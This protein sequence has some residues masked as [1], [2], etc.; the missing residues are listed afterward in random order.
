MGKRGNGEGSICRRPDGRWQGSVSLGRDDSGKLLRKYFYGKTRKEVA[1]KINEAVEKINKGSFIYNKD[2]P[3]AKIWGQIWLWEYKRNSIKPRTFDQ[4]ETLLRVHVF[5][6]IGDIKLVDLKTD[7]IQRLINE[8]FKNG[9][10]VRTIELIKV[11]LHAMLKQAKRNKLVNENICENVILPKKSKKEIRVLDIN[12]QAKLIDVLKGNYISRG[13]LLALYTGMRKGEVLALTWDDFDENAKTISVCKSLGR[14]RTYED[15]GAKT[16]LC[17]NSPKTDKSRRVIPL[18]NS[19]YEL[20][21]E[22]RKQQKK[23]MGLVGDFYN[24]NNLIFSNNTGTYID[25]G[26]FTR[27]LYK[28]CDEAGIQRINPHALRHSFATRGLEAD[29]SLKSLQE[30]LGHSSISITGDIYTHV[31]A[32]QKKKEISKLNSIF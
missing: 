16:K 12:E 2:N 3:T 28:C 11:I 27:K 15:S 8:M 31:L 6:A 30:L 22:H 1:D 5:P 9:S 20:L 32:E 23:Y 4:Y 26:N 25:P 29:M 13:L 19:A 7:H 17:I 18:I 14:I 21:T 10:S 24:D